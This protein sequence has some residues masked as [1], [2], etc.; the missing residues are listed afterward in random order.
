MKLGASLA[1]VS[2]ALVAAFPAYA[3]IGYYRFGWMGVLSAAIAGAVCWI[4]AA[5]ALMAT[6]LMHK[7][8]PLGGLFLGMAFRTGLPLVAGM[9]LHSSAP[10]LANAGIFGFVLC[11]YLLALAVETPLAV[12]MIPRGPRVMKTL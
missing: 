12:R 8:S 11:Y 3:G 4:G 7:Q 6:A 9:V 1:W 10:D 5:A 2:L